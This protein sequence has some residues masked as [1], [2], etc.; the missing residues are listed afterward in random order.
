MVLVAA[1]PVFFEEVVELAAPRLGA[2][3]RGPPVRSEP[4]PPWPAGPIF[5]A[6]EHDDAQVEFSLAFPSV[7]ER[8]RDHA[9]ALVDPAP[10]RRR[11]LLPAALRDRGAA[12]ARLLDPRQPGDLR[13]RGLFTF[14]GAC[15]AT[16]LE[17]VVEGIF[18]VVAGLWERRSS[19]ARSSPG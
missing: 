13:G 10:P 8:H 6:V 12:R 19:R 11:P 9:A 7:P 4:P 14:E 3:P 16:R 15:T 2:L 1:G 5:R 18:R 17:R